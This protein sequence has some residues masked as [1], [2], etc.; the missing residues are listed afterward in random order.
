MEL[1]NNIA[2]QQSTSVQT[3]QK[4]AQTKPS[5]VEE[6]KIQVEAQVAAA[7]N[8]RANARPVLSEGETKDLVNTLNKALNPFNTS[9][10][11][12]FDGSDDVF[13]VSVIDTQTNDTIRR[14]PSE[15]AQSLASKM[16]EIVG[17]IFDQKG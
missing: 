1:L 15:E 17:M 12:G 13:F 14:F 9:I 2:K 5:P 10:R 3:E 16:N 8:E 6:A 7:K 11:F 4:V